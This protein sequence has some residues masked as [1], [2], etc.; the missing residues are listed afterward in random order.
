MLGMKGFLLV[1]IWRLVVL[2]PTVHT[3]SAQEMSWQ[4]LMADAAKASTQNDYAE[5]EKLFKIALK[6]AEQFGPNDKRL[7]L[8]LKVLANFY[9]RQGKWAQAEPLFGRALAITEE[10]QGRDHPNVARSLHNLA[11]VYSELGQYS[12]SEALFLRSMEIWKETLG[13]K[14]LRLPGR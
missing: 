3:A 9:V 2:P 7:G 6:Q 10:N 13:P 8:N 12:R 5:A 4:K 1:G 14:T 11:Q